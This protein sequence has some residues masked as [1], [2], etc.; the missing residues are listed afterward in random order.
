MTRTP[1]PPEIFKR[2]IS[3]PTTGSVHTLPSQSQ[4]HPSPILFPIP[5]LF[6][7]PSWFNST[8]SSQI[9]WHLTSVPIVPAPCPLHPAPYP[10]IPPSSSS[11]TPPAPICAAGHCWR[12][13]P[14]RADCC[15]DKSMVSGLSRGSKLCS[16]I[17]PPSPGASRPVL[18][19]PSSN[20]PHSLQIP[21]LLGLSSR[22]S[23]CPLSHLE[24]ETSKQAFF[25]SPPAPIASSCPL[26][27]PASLLP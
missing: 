25:S 18:L 27:S 4:S 21:N 7:Q 13:S 6:V 17:L 5:F 8:L 22:R 23:T 11:S 26:L 19:S 2:N 16:A 14:S 24:S 20:L 15:H 3:P 1:R 9:P 10:R 12:N